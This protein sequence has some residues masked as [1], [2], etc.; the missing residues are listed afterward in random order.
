VLCGFTTALSESSVESQ[1]NRILPLPSLLILISTSTDILGNTSY[2]VAKALMLAHKLANRPT[3]Q[4]TN[5]PT[6]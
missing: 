5:L 4:L 6:N 1:L 3:D 2:K